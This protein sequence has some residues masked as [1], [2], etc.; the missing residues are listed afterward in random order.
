MKS[1]RKCE[2]EKESDEVM[3]TQMKR[4]VA[5]AIAAGL[6]S[7]QKSIQHKDG[8]REKGGRR[9]WENKSLAV[10]V[11]FVFKFLFVSLTLY[12]VMQLSDYTNWKFYQ[13]IGPSDIN[14]GLNEA[15]LRLHSQFL[16]AAQ[17]SWCDWPSHTV[18]FND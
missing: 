4:A 8:W 5:A 15:D 13:I 17:K 10:M 16:A 12:A 7:D 18:I 9:D 6:C 1:N 11:F 3:E 14:L 2:E